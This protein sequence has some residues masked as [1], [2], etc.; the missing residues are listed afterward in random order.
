M[1]DK[2]IHVMAEKKMK[3]IDHFANISIHDRISLLG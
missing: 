3:D 2:I 1:L